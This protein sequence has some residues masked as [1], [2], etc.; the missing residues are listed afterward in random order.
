MPFDSLIPQVRAIVISAAREELLPRFAEVSRRFK[1]DGSLV[2]AA[3][4]AMQKRMQIELTEHCRNT[5][6]SAK[7][8]L[9]K[10]RERF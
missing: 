8:C 7:K 10:S 5:I 9:P 1:A 2:T 3:D 6:S 4:M